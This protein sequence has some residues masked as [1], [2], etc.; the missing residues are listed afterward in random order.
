M[1]PRDIKWASASNTE[2]LATIARPIAANSAEQVAAQIV[3]DICE[4]GSPA[5]RD[6]ALR[7]DGFA[8][9][10][11]RVPAKALERAHNG[12]G[13]ENIDAIRAAADAVRRFHIRQGLRE[14]SMETWP[15]VEATR[16]VSPIDVAGI[17]VP[18][19]SAPLVSTLIMLAIPAQLAGVKRIAVVTPPLGQSGIDE[20]LL[21]A[22][23]VLGLD[24]IYALG[25]AQAIAALATGSAGLPRADKIFGP[26]NAYVAAAKT[27]V[28]ARPGGP[29]VDLPAGPSE[30]L[31]IATDDADPDFVASD[32]LSQA[33][34]DPLAQVMLVYSSVE[35]RRRIMAAMG[36]QLENLP[37]SDIARQALEHAGSIECADLAEMIEVTNSYA[38]EHLILHALETERL[39]REITNAGS[40]FVGGWTPEAA[41][42][43]AAGPNHTLPTGGAARA[44]SGLGVESFQKTTTI[45][46]AS[47]QGAVAI[48]P[49]VECLA[50]LEGLDAHEAAM[51]LRRVKAEADVVSSVDDR[52]RAA[53]RRRKTAE[54]DVCIT[55]NL[56]RSGPGSI[57]TGIGYFDHMLDQIGRHAGIAL[58]VDAVGDLEIDAHHTIEDVCLTLGETLREALGDKRGLARFGFELP[59]DE[60]RAG[61]WIDLSG[62]AIAR[63][64]GEIRGESVGGFPVEMTP[65]AFRSLADGLAAAIHVRVEGENAHHMIEACFKTFGRALGQAVRQHGE[66]L[67]STKGFLA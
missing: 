2:R 7:L 20:G 60:S 54:T 36:A 67:P 35:L 6:H 5:V 40:I 1:I 59:M 43:Y 44:Y 51:R 65:H 27:Q 50:R 62:R 56:D 41:G 23:S 14:Y 49:V 66:A 11:F 4:R 3:D 53:T 38:P 28:A 32:L 15:G 29:A 63:F 46:R 30:V 21:A 37:R 31:V 22:A 17:Y 12:F 42:D 45:L 52:P 16:R 10:D 25:G 57:S 9:A 55:V 33:E 19:G 13:T 47:A 8:P 18:S 26:G 64:D 39:L 34:H 58:S 48:A 24:E 61:V